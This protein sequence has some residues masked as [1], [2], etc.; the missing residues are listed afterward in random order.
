MLRPSQEG[1]RQPPGSGSVR[2]HGG[3][4]VFFRQRHLTMCAKGRGERQRGQRG[5]PELGVAAKSR[6]KV[7]HE[8]M[9]LER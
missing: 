9:G 2:G 1:L 6:V 8:E 3:G 7:S 5:Q 4:G